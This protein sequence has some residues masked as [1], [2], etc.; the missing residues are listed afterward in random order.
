MYAA[1][2]TSNPSLSTA[3]TKYQW[4]LQMSLHS[5]MLTVGDKKSTLGAAGSEHWLLVLPAS[6]PSNGL[7]V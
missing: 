4:K 6:A 2:R 7:P 3:K 5:N 1:A